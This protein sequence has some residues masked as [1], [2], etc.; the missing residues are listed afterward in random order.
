[1]DTVKSVA[2]SYV[3]MATEASVEVNELD[4]IA[5]ETQ[6]L[7]EAS[8]VDKYIKN[9]SNTGK[10]NQHAALSKIAQ[11]DSEHANKK[12]TPHA[13]WHAAE[14]HAHAYT[15]HRVELEKQHKKKNTKIAALHHKISMHHYNAA[16]SHINKSGKSHQ[17]FAN[18]YAGK[19]FG[20]HRA[21]HPS[22]IGGTYDDKDT[23]KH[24]KARSAARHIIK[25]KNAAFAQKMYKHHGSHLY[26]HK[27]PDGVDLRGRSYNDHKGAIPGLSADDNLYGGHLKI[28]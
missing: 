26:G 3:K 10:Y 14:S 6:N 17:E 28:K 4:L 2:E 11:H 20:M 5:E 27:Y 24:K 1:M 7:D 25:K 13:H 15:N 19:H 18:T 21:D 22:Y 12:N 8:T 9:H 23:P 16:I